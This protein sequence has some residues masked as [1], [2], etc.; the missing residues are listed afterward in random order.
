M[1]SN[2]LYASISYLLP[3]NCIG[4]HFIINDVNIIPPK[5][6][7]KRLKNQKDYKKRP[8]A[9]FYLER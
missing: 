3:T 8:L 2:L 4:I 5:Y 9:E 7:L 1:L 6:N